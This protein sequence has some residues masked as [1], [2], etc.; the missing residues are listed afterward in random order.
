[1]P[2]WRGAG[3]RSPPLRLGLGAGASPNR[4][5]RNSRAFASSASVRDAAAATGGGALVGAL[6]LYFFRNAFLAFSSSPAW[7]G[8]RRD[9]HEARGLSWDHE[10]AI[11]AKWHREDAIAA[12]T[13]R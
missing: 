8:R 6:A 13:S 3:A 12:T 4:P 7:H 1:M 10:D 2:R 5:A 11:D 9:I